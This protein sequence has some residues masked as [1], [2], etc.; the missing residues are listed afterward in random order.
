[1]ENAVDALKIAFG[2]LVFVIALT[3]AFMV[4][5]QANQTSTKMLFASDKTNYYSYSDDVSNKDGR[6]VGADVV[7]SSLYRYYQE[8]IVVRVVIG[9]NTTEFNTETDGG[10]SKKQ[11]KEKVNDFI[12]SS[13]L[14]GTFLETFDEVKKSGHYITEDDGSELTIQSGQTSIYITYTKQ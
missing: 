13:V 14:T 2:M 10:L 11:R 12:K 6:I 3:L 4:F 7:I 1:M 5:S 9:D 8:S